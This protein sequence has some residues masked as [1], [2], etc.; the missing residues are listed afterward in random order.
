[1]SP[2]LDCPASSALTLVILNNGHGI[3]LY[4]VMIVMGNVHASGQSN[5]GHL[6]LLH[7]YPHESPYKIHASFGLSPHVDNSFEIL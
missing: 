6:S 1:M 7:R 5:L 3:N 4:S 2:W